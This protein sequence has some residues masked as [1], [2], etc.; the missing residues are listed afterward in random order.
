MIKKE[1]K[2]KKKKK[3][4]PPIPPTLLQCLQGGEQSASSK[5]P[6]WTFTILSYL[7]VDAWPKS[8]TGRRKTKV[9]YGWTITTL[10]HLRVDAWPKS[11]M[12]GRSLYWV[13]YGWMHNQKS[14]RSLHYVA[15]WWTYDH[16]CLRV[17]G[18]HTKSPISGRPKRWRGTK[19]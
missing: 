18:Y 4:E 8:P 19:I 1:K 16:S 6:R 14:P 11:P 15:Y 9:A 2:K 13:T 10:G 5:L 12:G 3:S 7:W 17:D